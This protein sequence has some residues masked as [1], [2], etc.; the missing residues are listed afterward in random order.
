[1]TLR[2]TG[3]SDTVRLKGWYSASSNQ[4]AKF[5]LSDGTVL[6]IHPRPVTIKSPLPLHMGEAEVPNGK[7]APEIDGNMQHRYRLS[8]NG[9]LCY[10]A[11][12]A[13]GLL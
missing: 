9:A 3:G 11:A 10:K 5:Q 1:M 13:A 8:A 7:G 4:L 2:G 6:E 12:A